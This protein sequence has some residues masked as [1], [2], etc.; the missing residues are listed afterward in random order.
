MRI[1][2]N[3]YP[4][5]IIICTVWSIV[6]LPLAMLDIVG[7][8]RVFLGLPFIIFI[9]GYLLIFLLFPG[10]KIKS[11]IDIFERIILSFGMSIAI[12][13]LIGLG[14][15]YTPWGIH[16]ESMFS[17]IFLFVI[18]TSLIAT[19]RWLLFSPGERFIISFDL[20]FH[21]SHSLFDKVLTIVLA[22][23][24]IIS[25]S[26]LI[27]LVINPRIG[28]RFTEFY[29]LGKDGK[30]IN[31][32]TNLRTGENASVIIGV[33]NH[34]FKTMNYTIEIW[35][36]NQST[37]YDES[38]NENKSFIDHMWFMDKIDVTLEYSPLN[39]EEKWSQ[40]WSYNYTFNIEQAGEFK[41]TF[42]LFINSSMD[43]VKGKDYVGVGTQKI[44]DAYLETYL[45]IN[46]L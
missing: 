30:A 46:V 8:L 1:S 31:Y 7:P 20:S 32:S 36:I 17:L 42:L 6:L 14:L 43:Y 24:I 25:V 16:L 22:L 45:R 28:E 29:I 38:L 9:P 21:D 40:Q 39:I 15:N 23:L 4:I 18:S 27:Y 37:Y 35:L 33:S 34:E 3:K 5:D 44:Q 10:K 11:G 41:L 2:F 13:S 19:Y 26:F 12:V